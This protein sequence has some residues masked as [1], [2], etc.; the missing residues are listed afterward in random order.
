MH[1]HTYTHTM[2]T[3][4]HT[5]IYPHTYKNTHIHICKTIS[6]LFRDSPHSDPA[7]RGNQSV[8]SQ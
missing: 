6:N 7:S 1:T 5:Y 4:I 2:Y 3:H 8:E